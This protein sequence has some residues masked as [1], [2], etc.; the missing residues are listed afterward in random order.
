MLE[1]NLEAEV[2]KLIDTHVYEIKDDNFIKAP[3]L[4]ACILTY[5]HREFI[6]EALHGALMQNVDFSYEILIADDCSTDGTTKVIQEYQRENPGK[7]RLLLTDRNLFKPLRGVETGLMGVALLQQARGKYIALCE[8]DDYWTDPLKLQ[9]QVDFLESNPDFSICFHQ[10]KILKN[11]EIQDDYINVPSQITTIVDLAGGNY[12]HT[13]SCMFR[14]NTSKI[15][16]INFYLCPLGDY[17]IHMMNAQFGK[18]FCINQFM[19]FYRSHD[20]S[21]WSSKSRIYNAQKTLEAFICVFLDLP[22]TYS[23][24]RKRL[25]SSIVHLSIWTYKVFNIDFSQ[26]DYISNDNKLELIKILVNELEL[27]RKNLLYEKLIKNSFWSLVNILFIKI[28]YKINSTIQSL[29]K[30]LAIKRSL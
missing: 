6:E 1:Q 24:A 26:E 12:I 25:E 17:Y 9:K 3:L 2:Q 27:T 20:N 7:I 4:T 19:S 10:V 11:D 22:D 13:A 14:N 8:G 15:L 23:Q 28:T 29:V 18:I 30:I 16:G 5:N 21:V